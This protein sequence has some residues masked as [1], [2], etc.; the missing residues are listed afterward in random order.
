ML[1]QM[2]NYSDLDV[3]ALPT[4]VSISH[5]KWSQSKSQSKA[6]QFGLV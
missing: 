6:G 1:M 3:I 4:L 2:N 5:S